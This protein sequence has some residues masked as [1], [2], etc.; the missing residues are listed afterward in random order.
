MICSR[1]TLYGLLLAT[2]FL[3]SA[4]AVDLSFAFGNIPIL[5]M[6]KLEERSIEY[7]QRCQAAATTFSESRKYEHASQMI[8][9]QKI[10]M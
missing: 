1:S 8:L 9:G 2:C 10:K 6:V 3:A 7:D 5:R 4:S